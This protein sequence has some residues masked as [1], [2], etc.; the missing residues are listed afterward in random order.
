MAERHV[1]S[2]SHLRQEFWIVQHDGEEA[3]CQDEP[4]L[5][6]QLQEKHWQKGHEDVPHEDT[7]IHKLANMKMR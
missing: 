2:M 3:D 6:S 7:V 1:S 5:V 4:P